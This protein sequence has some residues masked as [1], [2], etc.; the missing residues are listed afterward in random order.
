MRRIR[1]R[2]K[3]TAEKLIAMIAVV[4]AAAVIFGAIGSKRIR[5]GKKDLAAMRIPYE[6]A[7]T[8]HELAKKYTLP[9][10]EFL[11][12]YA[13]DNRF[14]AGEMA[15][16][17]EAEI[18]R[19]YVMNY[20]K[21]KRQYGAGKMEPY[22]KLFDILLGEIK[23]FPIANEFGGY[24]YGDSFRLAWVSGYKNHD[25]TD[26]IDR[27]NVKGRLKAVGMAAGVVETCGFDEA[28]GYFVGIRASSGNYYYYA[29][30]DSLDPLLEQGK[31]I[32]AGET[33]GLMG[34]TGKGEAKFGYPVRLHIE[35]RVK[36]TFSNEEMRINP[37]IFLRL[38]ESGLY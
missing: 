10:P 7:L 28:D 3:Q 15:A 19:K 30:F 21:L 17:D 5:V 23:C 2:N 22:V 31:Q 20:E 34:S 11:A 27:E 37:Y 38:S 13:V 25:G 1:R 24:M 18:V 16:K 35:I 36:T 12:L 6:T 8:L 9:Y 32:A 26:I 4:L 33:L 14:F 29:H